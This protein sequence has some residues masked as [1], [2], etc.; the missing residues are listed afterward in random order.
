VVTNGRIVVLF[1]YVKSLQQAGELGEEEASE[2]L[3]RMGQSGAS[4][5][6]RKTAG[7]MPCFYKGNRP[8]GLFDRNKCTPASPL[9]ESG[10]NDARPRVII[11]APMP[12]LTF[13]SVQRAFLNDMLKA[14]NLTVN[15]VSRRVMTMAIS[16]QRH[17]FRRPVDN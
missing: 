4:I 1:V 3:G 2:R 6:P 14:Y 10:V 9:L 8:Y 15:N 17:S 12:R 5:L 7:P 13:P 16:G 11:S